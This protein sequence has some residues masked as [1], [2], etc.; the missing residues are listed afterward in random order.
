MLLLS[1]R[2]LC[3]ETL[4]HVPVYSEV[5]HVDLRRAPSGLVID[6]IC[7]VCVYYSYDLMYAL[8]LSEFSFSSEA[9]VHHH[10]IMIYD[11]GT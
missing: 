3:N 4:D 9:L 1:K 6:L 11:I 10:P 7:R 2:C 8:C 5:Q